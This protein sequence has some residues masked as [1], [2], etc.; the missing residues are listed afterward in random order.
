MLPETQQRLLSLNRD[1]YRQMAAPFARSRTQPQPGYQRLLAGL[2]QPAPHLLDVGCGDGRFGRYLLAH[3]AITGYTGVDFS[4]ELVAT[5]QAPG[6]PGF[7]GAFHPRDLSQ[8]GC[9]NDIGRFPAIACLATLQHIPGRANRQRL[10]AEMGQHL[11]TGGRLLLSNWQFLTHDR[12]RRKITDW[13]T[14]GLSPA[15]VEANDYLLTW[16]SGG[17]ALRYLCLIDEAETADLAQSAGLTLLSQFHSDGK[18]GDLNLY[19]ILTTGR[20]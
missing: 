14:I 18:E 17:F 9:L 11:A 12:Q 19:T 1:F 16:Q 15:D 3:Q 8:P 20:V 6:G 13:S 5:A 7:P 2:P 10:L 4:P